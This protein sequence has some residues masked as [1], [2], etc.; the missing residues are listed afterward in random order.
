MAEKKGVEQDHLAGSLARL[1]TDVFSMVKGDLEQ[2]NNQLLL[3]EK[4]NKRVAEEYGGFGDVALGLKVFVEQLNEK[5]HRFEEY[6]GQIDAID[7]Q[8]T[9]FEAVVSMLDKYVTLL[10]KKVEHAY[11]THH[12]R[13]SER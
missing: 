2:T 6:V 8:V 9:E 13:A 7:Q 5:N 3:L 1:F 12:F 4:M 11:R 10:E